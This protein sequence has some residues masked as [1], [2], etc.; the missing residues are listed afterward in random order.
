MANFTLE[1]TRNTAFT[2]I[3]RLTFQMPQ[4]STGATPSTTNPI[5]FCQNG[6]D[7]EFKF[8]KITS[9]KMRN[10]GN[11]FIITLPDNSDNY[12]NWSG[13]GKA[14]YSMIRFD[15]KEVRF[16]APAKDVVGS[17][18]YSKSI[19]IYFTFVNSD[20]NKRDIMIVISVIGQANNVGNAQT[21]GFILLKALANQIPSRNDVRDVTNMGN[22]NLG[23]LLPSNKAF[24]STIINGETINYIS[25]ARIIDIP[26]DFL[27][28]MIS[29]VIG[30]QQAF[31]QKVNQYTQQLISNPEGTIIFYSD[32]IKTIGSDQAYVCN[33]NCDRVIGDASLLQ[34]TFGSSNTT[35]VPGTSTRGTRN[36]PG[37]PGIPGESCEEEFIY[38]GT[39]TKVNVK[40]ASTPKKEITPPELGSI[41]VISVLATVM[42]VLSIAILWAMG[43]ASG[44][45][46]FLGYF[47]RQLWNIQN[48]SLITLGLVGFSTVI[49]GISFTLSI[50]DKQEK[51][52]SKKEE[53]RTQ[54]DKVIMANKKPYIGLIVGLSIWLLCIVPLAIFAFKNKRNANRYSNNSSNYSPNRVPQRPFIPINPSLSQLN[55][56][57]VKSFNSKASDI[58]SGYQKSP[59]DF[60]KPGSTGVSDILTASKEYSKLPELSKATISKYDPSISS[61]L[62]PKGEFIKNIQSNSPQSLPGQATLK[63]F[64]D[65]VRKYNELSKQPALITK[66]LIDYLKEQHAF[67][68][69]S[70][71]EQIIR[72]LTV[73][74]PIP[75]DVYQY[76][77]KM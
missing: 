50:L 71:L 29:R 66:N 44:V 45:N 62:N 52:G 74:E 28:N 14:G 9:A 21:D 13:S 77:S 26:E 40:S 27:N 33:A 32:N 22:V 70:K 47:S 68:K 7:I 59:S 69:N 24:F 10:D 8:K 25:M 54:N 19:Q 56:N 76:I 6:C 58:L 73:G 31:Q 17:I 64:I 5:L 51:I 4:S 42:V 61:F 63:S 30:S 75:L 23:N 16:A 20:Q 11:Y 37:T 1:T 12:I 15:L 72:P 55:P 3:P 57:Q 36:R 39:R 41:I 43:A 49:V 48:I 60:F 67:T 53:D 2:N 18:N 34:P 65:S 38:P 35:T 46:T